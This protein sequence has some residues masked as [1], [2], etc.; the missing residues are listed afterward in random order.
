VP[1]SAEQKQHVETSHLI[2]VMLTECSS[3]FFGGVKTYFAVV[4]ANNFSHQKTGEIRLHGMFRER[5]CMVIGMVVLWW[6]AGQSLSW[7]IYNTRIQVVRGLQSDG[8]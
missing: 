8:I 4:V 3:L 2:H 5:L 7:K 6:A 1:Y